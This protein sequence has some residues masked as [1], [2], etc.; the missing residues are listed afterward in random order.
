MAAPQHVSPPVTDQSR[1]Y[2]S[3]DH[4]PASW[5]GGRPAELDGGQ[6]NGARLGNPGPDQGYGL[7]LAKRLTPSLRLHAG[8][9]AADA[10]QGCLGVALRRASLFGRAPIIHDFTIAFTI[11]G[12]LDLTPP[13]ELVALRMEL[14]EGVGHVAH[15]YGE[16]R[17]IVDRIPE[18]TLRM[19]PAQVQAAYPAQWRDL[20]G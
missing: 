3:P 5:R 6:P 13:A 10:V 2:R 17:D 9:H 4:V 14:F 20:I 11:W 15:H 8:E 1:S 7:I 18:A 16:A 19:S 12:F